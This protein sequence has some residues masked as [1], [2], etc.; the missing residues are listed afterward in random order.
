MEFLQIGSSCLLLLSQ[1]NITLSTAFLISYC[2]T[3]FPSTVSTDS[4]SGKYRR[5]RLTAFNV[6]ETCRRSRP[7]LTEKNNQ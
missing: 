4:I 5:H 6:I 1:L 3:L 7:R 2:I